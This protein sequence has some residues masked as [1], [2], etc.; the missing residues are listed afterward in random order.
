MTESLRLRPVIDASR[1]HAHEAAGRSPAGSCRP[2]IRVY[3]AI[4]LIHRREDL[5]PSPTEFRPERFLDGKA[6][7]YSW[8]PFGGGIRRCIGAALAQAE[9]AEVIRVVL[10]SVELE[11][12]RAEA[13]PVVMRGITLVPR[14]GVPVR[15]GRAG[16][17]G[18]SG[19]AGAPRTA[20]TGRDSCHVA[21]SHTGDF[22]VSRKAESLRAKG[23][24]NEGSASP[25]RSTPPRLTESRIHPHMRGQS[26]SRLSS[27]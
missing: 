16:G 21:T 27:E 24:G 20:V 9:M 23:S 25:T 1:A 22:C 14:H 5:Y 2:A 26:S 19:A 12:V 13:D 6:E 15:A 11:P 3:P 17:R 8:L 4:V 7:S 18:R 10:E